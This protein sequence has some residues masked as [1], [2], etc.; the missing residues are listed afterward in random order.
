MRSDGRP[1]HTTPLGLCLVGCGGMGERHIRAYAMLKELG[2]FSFTLDTVCD[3]DVDR[4]E[5]AASTAERLLGRRPRVYATVHEALRHEGIDAFDVATDPSSH[6][7][8]GVQIL[9][10]GRHLICEKPLALTTKACWDLVHSA[11]EHGVVL[12]TAENLRR[13]PRIRTVRSIMESG[14]LGRTLLIAIEFIGGT[15]EIIISPWRHLKEKGSIALDLGV[16]H[17][18]L[19]SYLAGDFD[20]AFGSTFIAHEVRRKRK[21]PELDLESYRARHQEMPP[22]VVATGDDSVI[23][24]YRMKS[25]VIAQYVLILAGPSRSATLS[26]QGRDGSIVL[27]LDPSAGQLSV[28]VGDSRIS[29]AEIGAFV[30]AV[31]PAAGADELHRAAMSSETRDAALI[32]IELLDFQRAILAGTPPEVDGF[33]G[34]VAVAA[35]L[36]VSRSGQTGRAVRIDR[37]VSGGKRGG[38]T[39]RSIERRLDT[40]GPGR[41]SRTRT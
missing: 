3:G 9:D 39:A 31:A 26:V 38:P 32:A 36:A 28:T 14:L 35:V 24:T 8:V 21:A 4:A 34:L 1:R 29:E 27:P 23:A 17:T 13:D 11:S 19:I 25:G 7:S 22:S 18:D 20:A 30:D 10:A 6:R 5:R 15:D 33:Q 2:L 37:L 16:H 12:A 40:N 41:P